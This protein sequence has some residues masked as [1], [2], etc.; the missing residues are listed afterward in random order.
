MYLRAHNPILLAVCRGIDATSAITHDHWIVSKMFLWCLE[1]VYLNWFSICIHHWV[2]CD[3]NSG[4][5]EIFH[6]LY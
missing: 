1:A 3:T 6:C 4:V 2:T 5:C